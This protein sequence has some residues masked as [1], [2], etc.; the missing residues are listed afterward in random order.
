MK[1]SYIYF[2]YNCLK[3]IVIQYNNLNSSDF[4]KKIK[5]KDFYPLKD[6]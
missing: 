1:F 4:S 2:I 6:I 5:K 3:I